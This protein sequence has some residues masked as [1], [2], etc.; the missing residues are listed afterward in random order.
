MIK[1]QRIEQDMA[2]HM[3]VPSLGEEH[4]VSSFA[5]ESSLMTLSEDQQQQQVKLSAGALK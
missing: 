4:E 2:S 5:D 3:Q 1:R